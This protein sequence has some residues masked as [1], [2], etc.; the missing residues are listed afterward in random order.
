[1]KTFFH[2]D[3]RLH[4][5][6]SYLSRGQM[7]TP[8]EVPARLDALL[9]AVE[10]L[11]YPLEQPADHGRA[12]LH[13][14]HG[15]AYVTYLENAYRDWHQVPEDWGDEVMSNIYV[16]ENNPLRGILGQT[17]RYLADGSCPIGAQT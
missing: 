8:Q 4:H 9:A 3:Q 14:V 7:R 5:P 16:R 12:P 2:P 10:R 1:M 6:R 17:A 15:E 13:A 11:G